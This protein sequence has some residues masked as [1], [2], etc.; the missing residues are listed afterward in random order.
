MKTLLLCV[1]ALVLL[2]ANKS[3]VYAQ[4]DDKMLDTACKCMSRIDMNKSIAEIEEQAQK[5]MVEVMTTSPELM[6]LI[7]QSPDDA[8]EVGEKFGKEFG[9]ELMSKC[10][11]AM[12]LF[13][14]VGA[15]KKEVQESGSGK[16]KTS[17]LTG[18]LVKVDTKGYVTITVKTEGRDIT[19]LWL[20]YFPGS[21]QLKDGVAAFK[22]KKVKFQ[23][24][25][26]EVYNS[27]LKDYTTM[28]EITSFEVVP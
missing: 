13:I 22:G 20:R 3:N 18:T 25:E 26:I 24:K 12:Q 21:E 4:I 9:M 19:L 14:K 15:N 6:Q 8:R 5:C 27:V 28:K 7:A 10:P 16:T 23:W 2:F 11:A 1:L 17:S